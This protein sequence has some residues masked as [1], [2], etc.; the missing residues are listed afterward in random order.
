MLKVGSQAPYFVARSVDGRVISMKALSGT[1]LILYFFHKAFTPNCTVETKGFRDNYE[2]LR[3]Y[4]YEVVGV[5]TDSEETQCRFA[6]Q[7]EVTFP[8]VGDSDRT[9]SRLYDVLWPLIPFARRVTYVLDPQQT[10]LAMFRH[11]FQASK[12]LDEVLRFAR[13]TYTGQPRT[14]GA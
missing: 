10:I 8:M 5:S 4:G 7:H 3:T 13:L 12:H 14:S 9:I 11:E 6:A 1:P 2:E